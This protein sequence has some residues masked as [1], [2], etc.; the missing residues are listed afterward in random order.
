[1]AGTS[2]SFST[3]ADNG[4]LS[5]ENLTSAARPFF[6]AAIGSSSRTP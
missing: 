3:A 4:F 2:V 1:M 6:G 5:T